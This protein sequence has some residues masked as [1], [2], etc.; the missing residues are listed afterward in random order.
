M[1]MSELTDDQL[2]GLFRKSAEEFETPFDS[3]AWQDMQSRLDANDQVK[4]G[5]G[6]SLMATILRWGL[7]TVLLLLLAGWSI[8]KFALPAAPV[9]SSSTRSKTGTTKLDKGREAGVLVPDQQSSEGIAPLKSVREPEQEHIDSGIKTSSEPVI[10]KR[11]TSE[12]TTNAVP[13]RPVKTRIMPAGIGAVKRSGEKESDF[14][15]SVSATAKEKVTRF[16]FEKKSYRATDVKTSRRLLKENRSTGS[17]SGQ[18][19]R[20]SAADS[21]LADTPNNTYGLKVGRVSA[22]QRVTKAQEEIPLNE[23]IAG[24]NE[25]PASI[26]GSTA[27]TLPDLAELTV[28]PAKWPTPLSFTNRPVEAHPDTTAGKIASQPATARGLSVRFAVSPDLSGVGLKNFTRPG[29]NVGLFLEYRLTPRWSIQAGAIQSTKV[30]KAAISDYALPDYV[31]WKC[32]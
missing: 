11:S 30:Y 6:A 19:W 2:D 18:K 32:D 24:R 7:P 13:S 20:K 28:R 22:Q 14:S 26:N 21:E 25:I 1:S 3:A 12:S 9:A 29:T 4:P 5:S 31:L 27:V 8:Y 15:E 23:S 17:L 16:P 10:A